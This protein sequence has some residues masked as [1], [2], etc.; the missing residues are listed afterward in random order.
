[1]SEQLPNQPGPESSEVDEDPDDLLPV[2]I[3]VM[4]DLEQQRIAVQREQIQI[5]LR[6]LEIIESSDQRQ[7]DFAV[8]KLNA[9]DEQSKRQHRLAWLSLLIVGGGFL[10]LLLLVLAIAFWG[11]E[12][13]SEIAISIL[14][15]GGQA[16]GGGGFIFA[17]AYAIGR[18]IRR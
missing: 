16:L 9:D 5:A 17:V 11:N 12:K 13:Q 4:F 6:G 3:G 8:Q 15:V 7:Y 14:T 10:I 1:M 18:L 2:Q